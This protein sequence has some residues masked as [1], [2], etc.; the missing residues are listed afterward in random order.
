M[1]IGPESPVFSARVES[2]FPV[3]TGAGTPPFV[4]VLSSFLTSQYVSAAI[5]LG[6]SGFLLKTATRESSLNPDAK[7][8]SSSAAGLFQ[9][10]EQTWLGL[11][12][13]DGPRL[14][15]AIGRELAGPAGDQA[16]GRPLT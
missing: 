13:S 11:V 5:T 7:A 9:F 15:L 8:K 2:H 3:K 4:I 12:K 16:G 10:I 6:A 1:D 14:G